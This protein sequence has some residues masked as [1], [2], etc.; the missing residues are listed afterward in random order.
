MNY[1]NIIIL[2]YYV[3]CI[4]KFFIIK[5]F[6]YLIYQLSSILLCLSFIL[7]I[8]L[9][10]NSDNYLYLWIPL[11]PYC[12]YSKI[13]KMIMNKIKKKIYKN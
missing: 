4:Y 7:S 3:W 12:I 11:I 6:G 5:T 9:N 10:L 2:I 13:N 1:L 8:Y